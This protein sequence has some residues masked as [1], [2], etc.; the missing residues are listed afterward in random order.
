MPTRS[1][2]ANALRALAID[3]I[4]KSGSGHPGAPLGMAN[5]AESLWRGFLKHNPADPGW[6]DRDRFVLSNGHASMLL[7]GLLHLAGYALSMDEIRRFRQMGS[8]TPGHPECDRTPGVDMSTGPLGQGIATAVG[9]ALAERMLAAEFNRDGMNIVDHRT[10]VFLG[11][12]CLMEG[13]SQE[14]CSLAG[15]L[16][17][18]KLVALYDDNSISIDGRVNNWF[19]DDTP[20]RF[21]ACGWRVLRDVDG[22]NGAA[23]DAA[24]REALAHEDRPTLICCKTVI[25]YGSPHKAGTAGAHGAPL[26]PE[27]AAQ[28]RAALGWKHEPFVIPQEVYDAWDARPTGKKAQAAW[29]ELFARY[30]EAWPELAAEF[31]RRMKGELPASWPGAAE[32]AVR[33]LNAPA[34]GGKK[35]AT[36]AAGKSVLDIIAPSLPELVGGSAD[37]TGSVG[38]KFNGAVELAP[39][40]FAANYIHYGVREFA[41]STIMN[42]LA[43]HGGFIPYGGTFLVFSDYCR[44]AIRLA[45]LMK[46]RVI[47]VLTHDSIG[48]GEDG[49]THQPVE[50]SAGLRLTPGVDVW[51]PCDGA[52]SAV[53]WISAVERADGPSCLVMSRQGLAR[54]ERSAEQ[55][56]LIR[57]G[58]YVLRDCAGMPEIVL[59]SCG[60]EVELAVRAAEAL[61]A[62][63]RR[64]RVVSM[65]CCEV[66]DRQEA[67]YREDVLPS[68][69]RA[70]VAVEAQAA[71]WWW[72]YVGLDGRVV[73]MT[74]Y[75]ESAPAGELFPHFGFTVENVVRQAEEIL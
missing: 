26:G 66:F 55:L 68:A 6:V 73:G 44:N 60:S 33:V 4:E 29:N 63:G 64:A 48:V 52:E 56:A 45:A 19:A 38:T 51:R 22:L 61:E 32:E 47:W 42:G 50:Q 14:A 27:E 1:E 72:T 10:W 49:P 39:G 58:G 75:G 57:R 24:I 30:A 11:D 16:G 31:A 65:P 8:L 5:M 3:A 34:E 40:K 2:L 41:M 70:R 37:L 9:M 25:G 46:K 69:V 54:Q 7:Y 17:L 18:G 23:V 71:D 67:A 35:I 59:I 20:A 13:V 36:R 28:T 15:T 53:A 12:G 62:K 74:T 21:E 43:L